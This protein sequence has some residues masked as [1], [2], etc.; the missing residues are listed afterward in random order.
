MP[1]EDDKPRSRKETHGEKFPSA[2]LDRRGGDDLIIV[3]CQC[4]GQGR[5]KQVASKNDNNAETPKVIPNQP[6]A[7][8]K[9]PKT[10]APDIDITARRPRIRK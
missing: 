4:D 8:T 3:I 6:T 10:T 5:Q 1:K 2:D 9:R 7:K